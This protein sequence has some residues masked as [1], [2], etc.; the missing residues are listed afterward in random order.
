MQGLVMK[1]GEAVMCT[2]DYDLFETNINGK[3]GCF[4]KFD[5]LSKKSLVWFPCNEEWAELADDQFELVNQPGHIAAKYKDFIS[6]IKTLEYSF[7]T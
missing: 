7:P 6:C 5:E 3:E 4:I 1:R 2:V